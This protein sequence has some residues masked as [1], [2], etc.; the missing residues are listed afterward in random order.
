MRIQPGRWKEVAGIFKVDVVVRLKFGGRTWKVE[1]IS[2]VDVGIN[3]ER[4]ETESGI[5]RQAPA[6]QALEG[7]FAGGQCG[8][9][10][11]K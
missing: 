6:R 7:G 3:V 5:A 11:K 4:P 1:I 2:I 9:T 10:K 8:S